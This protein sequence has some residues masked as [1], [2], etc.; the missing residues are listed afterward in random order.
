MFTGS[1]L[2]AAISGIPTRGGPADSPS[3]STY[4]NLPRD[5]GAINVPLIRPEDEANFNSVESKINPIN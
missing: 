2:V 1:Q 4:R 5:R 3:L